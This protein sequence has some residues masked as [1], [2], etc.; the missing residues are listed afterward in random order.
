MERHLF[1]TNIMIQLIGIISMAFI[2]DYIN[3][4]KTKEMPN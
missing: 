2:L 1:M 4:G 3:F